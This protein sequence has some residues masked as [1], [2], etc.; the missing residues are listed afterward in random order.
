MAKAANLK[1]QQNL[2]TESNGAK[3]FKCQFCPKEFIRQGNLEKHMTIHAAQFPF[4]CLNCR[5]RFLVKKECKLHE[6][7][8]NRVRCYLCDFTCL[9]KCQLEQHLH[10][11]A[12]ELPFKCTVC[13]RGF[14]REKGL[15]VHM[16]THPNQFQCSKCREG[17]SVQQKWKLH[18]ESCNGTRFEC[19]LCGHTCLRKCQLEQHMRIHTRESLFKCNFCVKEY[20]RK[21]NFDNHMRTHAYLF[22]FKCSNCRIGF[23]ANE[24]WESH[25]KSCNV[26]R[27]D[28]RW[29]EYTCLSRAQLKQHIPTHMGVKP[30]ACT[31]E[32]C[33]KQFR[34]QTA[35]QNHSRSHTGEMPFQCSECPKRFGWRST[36]DSHIKLG[37]KERK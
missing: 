36:L 25:E 28:C 7:S 2:A 34:T 30:Y 20:T 1:K 4:R 32:G 17:F 31:F 11:H 21:E 3:Q 12:G 16:R 14:T 33:S 8:C 13:A 23:S 22:S 9:R 37:H 5:Q 10:I 18:E 29:C 24:E 19:Y 15:E 35:R 6:G 27:F 26:K